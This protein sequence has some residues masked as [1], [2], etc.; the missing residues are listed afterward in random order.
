M[1]GGHTF[2]L[3]PSP[4]PHTNDSST[5]S[6]LLLNVN[7]IPLDEGYLSQTIFFVWETVCR[8]TRQGCFVSDSSKVDSIGL[9]YYYYY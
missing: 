3:T 2:V 1:D 5:I 9:P 6:K 7:V 4:H 8:F